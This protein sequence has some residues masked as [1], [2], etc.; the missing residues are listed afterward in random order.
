ML[1]KAMWMS[2]IQGDWNI[3]IQLD[4][5]SRITR[6]FNVAS[7]ESTVAVDSGYALIISGTRQMARK[8]LKFALTF[9]GFR[10]DFLRRLHIKQY[11]KTIYDNYSTPTWKA[12][13][14][15]QNAL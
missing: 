7:W 9:D 15:M 1:K 6:N 12:D 4:S 11:R 8:L 5:F 10:F 3:H 2:F 13:G 14:E